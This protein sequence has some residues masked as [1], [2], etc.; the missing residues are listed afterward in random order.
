MAIRIK[1]GTI[2]NAGKGIVRLVKKATTR[3]K[4][5]WQVWYM[6][7]GN[8]VGQ[9]FMGCKVKRGPGGKSVIIDGKL[10]PIDGVVDSIER[11]D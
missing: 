4:R 1:R 8:L 5:A 6:Q 9:R 11:W 3:E 7:G 2:G 10:M